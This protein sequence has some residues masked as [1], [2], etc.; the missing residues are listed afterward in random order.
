MSNKLMFSQR[1]DPNQKTFPVTPTKA[2][3]WDAGYDLYATDDYKIWAGQTVCISTGIHMSIPEGYYGRVAD[4]SS[5]AKQHLHVVG[6]VIDSSYRGEIKV[7]LHFTE[8][9][10]SAEIKAGQKFAQIIITKICELE[11]VVVDFADLPDSVRGENGFG[12][13]GK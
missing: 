11:P 8:T 6:G 5:M 3:P 7:L 1:V 2:N 9:L 10:G 12:S 13:S 4:R